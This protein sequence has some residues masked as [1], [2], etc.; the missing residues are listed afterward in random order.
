MDCFVVDEDG[1][2]FIYYSETQA[3]R[4]AKIQGLSVGSLMASKIENT[5]TYEKSKKSNTKTKNS[6]RSG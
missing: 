3:K 5:E 2:A 6:K 1:R 4:E